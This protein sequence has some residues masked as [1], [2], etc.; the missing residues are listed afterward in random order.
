MTVIDQQPY[1]EHAVL[2]LFK[3][4]VIYIQIAHLTKDLS[5]M[6]LVYDIMF[7]QRSCFIA[8]KNACQK[9]KM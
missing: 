9:L 8:I 7:R 4:P 6:I 2:I 1:Y 5:A 3:E